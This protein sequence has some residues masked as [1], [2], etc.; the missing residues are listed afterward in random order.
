MLLLHITDTH[1]YADPDKR[2]KG[3]STLESF[4]AVAT[5]AC[6][7]F[8]NCDAV[9]LGG[10]LSQDEST[11]AYR[12]I[13]RTMLEFSV[14]VHAIAGNHD[15]PDLMLET[16]NPTVRFNAGVSRFRLDGWQVLLVN[17]HDA[18]KVSGL[19]SE[20]DLNRLDSL[21][22]EGADLHQLV[23]MHHHPEPI[24]SA[25][26]DNIKLANHRSFWNI[27]KRHDSLKGVLFGH[28]HQAFDDVRGDVRLLGTPSTTLQFKP[29]EDGF[30]M[31]DVSP[32]YRWLHLNDDG[33]IESAV[34]RVEG[35]IPPDL[36]DLTGY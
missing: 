8:P 35:H 17:S 13:A 15:N 22:E 18:G 19:I 26:M 4:T 6:K 1:L 24:G 30:M 21:L 11:E 9:V 16:L 2:L 36:T 28:I 34:E 7:S 10:D 33:S 20:D 29:G 23:V 27:A 12:T 14:P 5:A 32:G 25:W 3:I 31:D